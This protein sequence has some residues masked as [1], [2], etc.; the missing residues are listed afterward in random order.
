LKP[1]GP[2]RLGVASEY[3]S[4]RAVVM[5][6]PRHFRVI[7]PVNATQERFFGSAPPVVAALVREQR[8]FSSLLESR[9]VRIYWA[10]ELPEAPLQLNTRDVGAVVGDCYI[11]GRM[12]KPIRAAEPAAVETILAE[13]EGRRAAVTAGYFEG[14]DLVLGGKDVFLGVGERTDRTGAGEVA[15]FL[16]QGVRLHQLELAPRILHLD[17]VLTILGEKTALIYRDGLRQI[18]DVLPREYDLIE[19]TAE[20]Q[21]RLATNV[22]CVDPRTVVADERNERVA[23]LLAARGF[24]V[25]L[26]P[27][28]ETTKIGGAFRCMTL[29]L[30]RTEQSA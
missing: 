11:R 16:P 4:L 12:R 13:F 14:G 9:G 30:V 26:L 20:E 1:Q 29:P 2:A 8:A 17:V 5:A 15:S 3:A 25:H 27:F 23:A 24:E 19:V 18:P 6:T 22:F 7:E 21:E 28:A 10:D